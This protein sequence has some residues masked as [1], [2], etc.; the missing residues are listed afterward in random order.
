ME[1]E[2]VSNSGPL[3]HLAQIGKF[4]IL[5][6]FDRVYIPRKVYDEVNIEGKPGKEELNGLKNIIIREVEEKVS[7]K[8]AKDL[9]SFLNRRLGGKGGWPKIGA[10]SSRFYRYY[11]QGI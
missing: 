1:H 11:C 8:I 2:A 5:K 10:G 4:H 9:K 6:I 7:A 3:I